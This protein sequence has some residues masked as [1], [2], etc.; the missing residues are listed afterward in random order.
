M[1]IKAVSIE[2]IVAFEA[3]VNALLAEGYVILSS[4]AHPEAFWAILEKK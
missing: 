1:P 3:K 4:G 2:S